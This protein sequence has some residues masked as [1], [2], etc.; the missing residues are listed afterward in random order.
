M[1]TAFVWQ[2]DMA[3]QAG[4]SGQATFLLPDTF[5]H[6][7]LCASLVWYEV[8]IIPAHQCENERNWLVARF[9]KL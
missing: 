1:I 3:Q 5:N 2:E 7:H 8:R 4:K 9:G 6:K